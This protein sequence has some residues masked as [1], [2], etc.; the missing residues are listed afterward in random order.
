MDVSVIT[1]SYRSASCIAECVRSVLE[2]EGVRTEMI[3][4]DNASPD[5]T[6]EVLRGLAGN[7]KVLENDVNI[8]F[9]RGCNQGFAASRGRFIHFLNPDARLMGPDALATLCEAMEQH[10]AWGLAGMRVLSAEG[11]PKQPSTEYP[12]Q[13]HVRNDFSALPGKIAWVGGASMMVRRSVFESLGGF[14]PNFFLYGEETDL[15]LR[16]RQ[17][18]HEIGYVDDVEVRHIGA[19]SER[20]NDPYDVW[21]RHTEGIQLF[22]KKHYCAEDVGRLVRRNRL[23][24]GFRM[25]V[26]GLAARFQGSGSAAWQKYRRYRATWEASSKFLR[27][28]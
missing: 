4:V 7:I 18:G 14:D 8:G 20:G 23:R 10:A 13:R 16:L 2:Q 24:A 19:G 28:R 17:Q 5:Q 9:G 22:W 1:V 6:V 25:V 27:A 26:N 11:H 12:D 21:T 15:C 3:I